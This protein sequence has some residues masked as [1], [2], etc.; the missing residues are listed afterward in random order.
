MC[1]VRV[2]DR[3][4]WVGGVRGQGSGVMGQGSGVRGQGSGLGLGIYIC[5]WLKIKKI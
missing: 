5:D 4:W 1:R 3:V 2:R